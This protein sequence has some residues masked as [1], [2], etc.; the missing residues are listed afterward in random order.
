MKP[1]TRCCAVL[2]PLAIL[3]SVAC[4]DTLE[5]VE[6]TIIEQG[7]TI[8][9]M[10]WKSTYVSDN[11]SDAM[12]MHSEGKTSYEFMTKGD[13]KLS[14]IETEYTTVTEHMRC[15]NHRK[16]INPL[17]RTCSAFALNAGRK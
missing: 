4:G 2:A 1:W 5:S 6:K 12:K 9:S 11:E 14:R 17:T 8:N 3:A 10:S 13:K 15:A 16:L 7:K